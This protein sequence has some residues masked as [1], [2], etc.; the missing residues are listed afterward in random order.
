MLGFLM[1][2]SSPGLS[3]CPS[4][5]RD[6]ATLDDAQL[7]EAVSQALRAALTLDHAAAEEALL[8]LDDRGTLRA[9]P[10]TG[11]PD[12]ALDGLTVTARR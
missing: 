6:L 9:C 11:D 3:S 12:L 5:L 2:S 10:L 1:I 7:S 4:P 8:L